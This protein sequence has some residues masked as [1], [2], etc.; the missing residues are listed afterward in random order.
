MAD[1]WA[2]LTGVGLGK[3]LQNSSQCYSYGQAFTPVVAYCS[4]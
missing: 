3:G 4:D 2:H 1:E